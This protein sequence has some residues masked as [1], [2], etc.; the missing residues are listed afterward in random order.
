[1]VTTH[2]FKGNAFLKEV[3]A[4]TPGGERIVHCLQC[5]TCGGSCPSGDAMK[6]TPRAIF[7]LINAG[8]R[9]EVLTSNTMWNCVSCYFC[10]ARCPQQIPVTDIMY[11]L[12]RIAMRAGLVKGTTAPALAKS[13]T[14]WVEHYGRTFEVGL[15]V[16]Y[17]GFNKPLSLLGMGPMGIKMIMRNRMG[18]L[19]TKI[20]NINQLQA[21]IR[22]ARELGGQS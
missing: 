1:M 3:L 12:K 14:Y 20:R 9:K 15:A 5:G 10:T 7:S 22:K 11:S 8:E 18:M 16:M 13:F 6:H 21:I 4:E 17:Y 19:P 2:A